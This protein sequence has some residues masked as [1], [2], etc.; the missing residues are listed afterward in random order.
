MA[1]SLYANEEMTKIY[2]RQFHTVYRVCLSF[3]KNAEDA[4]DMAQETFLKL[5]SCEKRFESEEHEKAWLIVTASNTCKDELRKWKRRLENIRAHFQQET[6][7]PKE[8]DRVLEWVMAL[9]VKYKQVIYLHYY[10]GYRTSEIAGMLH[11]PESTVRNQLLRGRKLLQ[12][13]NSHPARSGVLL[14]AVLAGSLFV[15]TTVYA[16]YFHGLRDLH[17]GKANVLDLS[18]RD[19]GADEMPEKD[20]PRKEVDIISLGGIAG[21]PEYLACSEWRGFLE[22]YDTDEAI[23]SEIGN[24]FAGLPEE[25]ELVYNCYTREMADKVDELCGR[26]GLSRLKGFYLTG[27]YYDLCR[28]ASVG[29]ICKNAD[30]HARWDIHDSYLYEDGTFHMEGRVAWEGSLPYAA[31]FQLVRT[32]KGSFNPITLNIGTIE[33]YSEWNYT[34]GNAQNILLANSSTKALIIAERENSFIVV[35]V[36]GDFS[37]DTFEVSDKMLEELADIFDFSVIP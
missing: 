33:E 7:V 18:E 22:K 12:K 3:M 28:R 31:D 37:S 5:L 17:L 19:T 15:A 6:V 16:A 24:N 34:T 13:N 27:N 35:N 30:G 21:S 2:N 1:S 10:E 20:V 23:L 36:L 8:D 32:M 25:Y 26:F 11:C 4:E 29:D 9:P 14:A